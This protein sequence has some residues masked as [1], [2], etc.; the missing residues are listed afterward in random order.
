MPVIEKKKK[1]KRKRKSNGV[2]QR[3]STA[4]RLSSGICHIIG[5][6]LIGRSEIIADLTPP[7]NQRRERMREKE[8]S[9][10][11][12]REMGRVIVDSA[13]RFFHNIPLV[14]IGGFVDGNNRLL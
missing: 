3:A 9:K 10:R 14:Q 2:V 11:R 13:K 7:E 5:E 1:K 12:K 4:T 8:E 6:E